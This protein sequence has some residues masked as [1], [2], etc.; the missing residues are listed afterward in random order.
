[1]RIHFSNVNFSS[2]T[3][4]NTFAHRL[5][6]ELSSMGHAIVDHRDYDTALVFIEPGGPLLPGKRIVQ[7][8]DGIWFKPSEFE[9]NNRRILSTYSVAD[10]VIWQSS[11]DRDMIVHHWGPRQGSVV[12]NGID[13]DKRVPH[14]DMDG[15]RSRF[16]KIFVTSANW[17]R[18]KR[19][20]ETHDLFFNF[21]RKEP[22]SC[23]LVMGSNPDYTVNENGVF[24]LGSLPHDAC[25]SIYDQVDWMIHLAWLDHCP[26]VVVEALSRGCPVICTDSGGTREIVKE[27]GV[28]IPEKFKY[29]F[30]LLDYDDPP[31]LD[32]DLDLPEKISVSNSHLDIKEVA[33]RYER[34]LLGVD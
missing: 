4:P 30:E 31:P 14:I 3:G 7:R 8:L 27:N 16:K 29:N 19:L 5:A 23:L 28:V 25:L 18:Q 1:M 13:L 34:I 6:S 2:R 10:H 9:T 21:Q 26:N 17:H 15:L 33:K 32:L 22:D 11:F 20:R 12:S 24:Y